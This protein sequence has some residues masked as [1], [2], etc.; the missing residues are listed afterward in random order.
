MEFALV[1]IPFFI[2][3]FGIFQVALYHFSLQVLE[4]ATRKASRQIMTAQISSA[5]MTGA[6]FKSDV[7]CPALLVPLDC[8]KITVSVTKVGK[9]A[10]K[11]EKK[12]IYAF[13]NSTAT[14]L[15]PANLDASVG[16]FA[17]GCGH[18]YLFIDV[19]YKFP[20]YFKYSLVSGAS[21]QDDHWILRSTNFIYNE[22]FASNSGC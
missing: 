5:G 1:S 12:D 21:A 8:N 19:A 15:L 4:F 14:D 18:D 3:I 13:L 16:T 6:K 7:L 11:L 20:V 9:D 22:P 2:F 17:T 10:D